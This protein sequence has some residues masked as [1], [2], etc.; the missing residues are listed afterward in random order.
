MIIEIDKKRP[1]VFIVEIML[2][3]LLFQGFFI[4]LGCTTNIKYILDILNIA[5]FSFVL[6]KNINVMGIRMM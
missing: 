4:D 1:Y 5:L 3:L 6:N 2:F